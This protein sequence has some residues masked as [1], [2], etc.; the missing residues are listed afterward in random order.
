MTDIV[1]DVFVYVLGIDQAEDWFAVCASGRDVLVVSPGSDR[2]AALAELTGH[3][4]A[5]R[6]VAVAAP[7]TDTI[8]RVVGGRVVGT[9]DRA[10]LLALEPP[11]LLPGDLASGTG[12]SPPEPEALGRWWVNATAGRSVCYLPRS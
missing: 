10:R 8:K 6:P 11:L 1:D 12:T 2:A 7:V 3:A 9:I 5:G 4:S